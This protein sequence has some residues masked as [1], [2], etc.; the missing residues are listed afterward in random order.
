MSV[1]CVVESAETSRPRY[2][3]IYGISLLEVQHSLFTP[4]HPTIRWVG[5]MPGGLDR[6]LC[7][8]E[9]ERESLGER[10][11]RERKRDRMRESGDVVEF[12]VTGPAPE[13]STASV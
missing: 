9:R 11:E 4:L 10:R 8:G 1:A 12:M 6:P 5:K 3:I 7:P 13:V 2:R